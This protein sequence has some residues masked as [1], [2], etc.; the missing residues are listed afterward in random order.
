MSADVELIEAVALEIVHEVPAR[1]R[2]DAT[3]VAV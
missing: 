1:N 2:S 3:N